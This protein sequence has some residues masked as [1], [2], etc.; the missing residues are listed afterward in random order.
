MSG[1]TIGLMSLGLMV[2]IN[3]VIVAMGYGRLIELTRGIK[4][5]LET[6]CK[7]N[8]KDRAE[9]MKRIERLEERVF[10]VN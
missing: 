2:V 5:S 3:I 8:E 10:N 9:E 7:Q 6:H 1:D 4:E